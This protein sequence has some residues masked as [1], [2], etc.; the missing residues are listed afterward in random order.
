[1]EKSRIIKRAVLLAVLIFAVSALAAYT[2]TYIKDYRK[3]PLEGTW[4]S[5][6]GTVEF[7][8]VFKGGKM[9][10][11]VAMGVYSPMNYQITSLEEEGESVY[12]AVLLS[13]ESTSYQE[14]YEIQNGDT[15]IYGNTVLKKQ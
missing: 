3:D 1:M 15:M 14:T 4:V 7:A 8:V 9:T 11:Q 2:V 12:V 13:N 6:E 10:T 5:G